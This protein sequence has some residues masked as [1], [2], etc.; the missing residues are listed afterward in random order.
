MPSTRAAVRRSRSTTVG[1][2]AGGLLAVDV[3]GVGGQQVVVRSTSR[4]AAASSAASLASVD[5]VA[6]TRLAALARAPSSATA[7]MGPCYGP[8]GAAP[9]SATATPTPV[10]R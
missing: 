6:S 2:R 8:S 5:A 7:D 10:R 9:A 4:S 1:G 3:V